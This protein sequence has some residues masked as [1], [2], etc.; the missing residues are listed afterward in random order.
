MIVL[1]FALML[2]LTPA[3]G[4]VPNPDIFY[5]NMTSDAL[6]P[7]SDCLYQSAAP[8]SLRDAVTLAGNHSVDAY[9]ELGPN[10]YTLSDPVG[11][12]TGYLPV[13]GTVVSPVH[14]VF[15][16]GTT[17]TVINDSGNGGNPAIAGGGGNTPYSLALDDVTLTGAQTTPALEW[18][19]AGNLSLQSVTFANNHVQGGAAAMTVVAVGTL[20]MSGVSFTG[21]H[22]DQD[23][24]EAGL[25]VEGVQG[26]ANLSGLQFSHNVG[27]AFVATQ[28]SGPVNLSNSSFIDNSN[29]ARAT[30]EIDSGAA[31]SSVQQ[32][33][34]EGNSA[35]LPFSDATVTLRGAFAKLDGITINGN[36]AATDGGAAM[37]N[38]I[39]TTTATNWTVSGNQVTGVGTIAAVAGGID[40][41]GGTL[42]LN[43]A[44]VAENSAAGNADDL[45]T[46]GTGTID[47]LNSIVDGSAAAGAVACAH[48]G[49]PIVSFGHNVDRGTSC[50][51]TGTGDVSNVDPVLLP[52][53]TPLFAGQPAVRPLGYGSPAV[54]AADSTNCPPTDAAGTAR[55]QGSACDI[56][57]YEAILTNLSVTL[58]V[59]HV[60][61]PAGGGQVTYSATVSNL[62]GNVPQTV[63][64]SDT[65]P[66]GV[67]ATSAAASQGTCTT[68]PAV[69][70]ALG[71]VH[72]GTNVTVTVVANLSAS[73]AQVDSAHV[74]SELPDSD[75]GND[76][77]TATTDVAAPAVAVPVLSH[78]RISPRSFRPDPAH[79]KHRRG[80]TITYHDTAAA[81]STLT[82]LRRMPGIRA[83]RA[84]VAPRHARQPSKPHRCVRLVAAGVLRHGDNAGANSFHFS[85]RIGRRALA[86]GTYTLRAVASLGAGGISAPVQTRFSIR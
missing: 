21:N 39:G 73:G 64:F 68:T 12:T 13:S 14:E 69:S 31:P 62:S 83:G 54:N 16:S 61:L 48:D 36:T 44:T 15:I 74:Q 38:L 85:G 33:D 28:N 23:Q 75:V 4:A 50:G 18:Q 51:F 81:K 7:T 9:V 3:A 84:C 86:R 40:V 41:A 55:P 72:R 49:G 35:T 37:L 24:F 82:I 27:Q 56:G 20:T 11:S 46:S 70:C 42:R 53:T 47:V 58:G 60:S 66:A 71:A 30:L 1:V 5:P 25:D 78:L 29:S 59:D 79:G 8:C 2:A 43:H 45:R 63:T 67:H 65:L 57:S 80:A 22:G 26:A 32:V 17:G 76:T 10:T 6:H 34:V 77:A 19:G 52:L